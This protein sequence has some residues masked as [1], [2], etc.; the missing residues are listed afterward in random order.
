[1]QGLFKKALF[2]KYIVRIKKAGPEQSGLF[3]GRSFFMTVAEKNYIIRYRQ[4]GKSCTEIARALGLSVN[5]V[6]SFCQR[7]GIAPIGQATG[8]SPAETLCLCC[9]EK[10]KFQPHRKP[11]RFCSDACRLHWWHAHRDMEKS[12]V[13][14]R[15]LSCGRAFRS[16]REQKYCSHACYIEARFGGN[17][18][19]CN[20]DAKAV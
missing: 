14:R 4:M 1:M 13:D 20:A 18:H 7:S 17:T 9:G 2:C 12:A 16:S 5:T 11:K 10:I 6:K 8:T 15:C 19:G 3:L